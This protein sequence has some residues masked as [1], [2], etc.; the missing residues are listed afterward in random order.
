MTVGSTS[1]TGPAADDTEAGVDVVVVG[2]GNAGASAAL[3][4]RERGCSVLVVDRAPIEWA[5]GNSYFTA[6]A[7]RTTYDSLDDIR[8]LVAMSDEEAAAIDIPAYSVEDFRGDL[9]RVTEGRAD[10][11]LSDV[12]AGEAASALAWLAAAGVEWEL[13][14]AR[15]SFAVGGRRRYWGNLVIGAR[16][17]GK[18]LVEAEHIAMRNAGIRIGFETAFDD[19]ITEERQV[20]GVVVAS[21]GRRR[22]IPAGAVILASGGFQADPARRAAYLGPGWDLAKVRGTPWNTGGPLFRAL[23]LGAAPSG[24]WSGAHAISW[25]AAAPASGDRVVTNRYSRQGYPFGLM[26]NREGRRFVDEGADFRNYTYAR[27]GAEVLRQSGALAYQLFDADSIQYVSS[28]DYDTAVSSRTEAQSL[29]AL[30]ATI[31]VDAPTLLASIAAFNASVNDRPFDPTIKDGR[32]TVG[33][34]PPKSNWAL[35]LTRPPFVAFA[36]TCGI[37][38]TF[39]GLRVDSQAAVV[40][41]DGRPIDGLFAAGEIVGGLFYHNYPGGSGLTAGTVLGRRAGAAAAAIAIAG[42]QAAAG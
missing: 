36:V 6:G 39:G 18:G 34:E 19:F 13:M 27:Y 22:A 16:G 25:D 8:R 3:A 41:S 7:F 24:H 29:D 30:A 5:G 10:P 23:D 17:G 37:T 15:Q 14:A 4:A 32:G 2:S 35:P 1:P 40:G 26:V 11:A 12:V 20:R 33:I 21:G 42:R 38:F 28:V 9:A 31:D